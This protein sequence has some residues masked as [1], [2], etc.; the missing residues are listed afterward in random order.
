[1]I[2]GSPGDDPKDFYEFIKCGRPD[3]SSGMRIFWPGK[4]RLEGY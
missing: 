4:I 3:Q 1:M 2:R